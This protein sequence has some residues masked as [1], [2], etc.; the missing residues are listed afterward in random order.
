MKEKQVSVLKGLDVG[1]KA[2]ITQTSYKFKFR[3]P[4]DFGSI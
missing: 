2:N 4:N 3:R 1:S